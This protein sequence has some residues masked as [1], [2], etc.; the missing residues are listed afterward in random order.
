MGFSDPATTVSRRWVVVTFIFLGILISYVDRGNLGIAAPVDYARF[1]VHA[2]GDGSAAVGFLLDVRDV[3]DPRRSAGGPL[4]DSAVVCG[5]FSV[6][7]DLLRRRSDSAGAGVRFCCFGCCWVWRKRWGRSPAYPSYAAI[8]IRR[9]EG[10]P[11]R[12][13]SRGK[14]W[15][16]QRALFWA[17]N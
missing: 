2:G 3:S 8:L 7:V 1:R 15:G 16:P 9:P 13:T 12:S 4:W 11:P 5:R 6:V 14:I 10:C 17:R